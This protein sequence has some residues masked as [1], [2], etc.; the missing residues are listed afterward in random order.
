VLC[1]FILNHASSEEE[2]K[3]R[4]KELRA[5]LEPKLSSGQVKAARAAA[6]K[7]TIDL[8]VKAALETMGNLWVATR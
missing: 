6:Q 3:N 5:A 7:K 1:Y 4:A 8:M 2:T